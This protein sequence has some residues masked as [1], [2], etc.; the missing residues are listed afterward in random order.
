[1][2]VQLHSD[3]RELVLANK[4]NLKGKKNANKHFYS[5]CKLLPDEWSEQRRE[6]QQA[7]FKAHHANDNKDETQEKDRIEIK[8]RTLFI[9]KVPQK[10]LLQPPKIA[11]LFPERGE[12]E[13]IDRMKLYSSAMATA[14]SSSFNAHVIKT[15]ST[16][17]VRCGYVKVKQM[18]P[19]AAHIMAA[20]TIKNNIEGYQDDREF[21]AAVRI[22]ETINGT[23]TPNIAVYVVRDY[24]GTHI[25]PRRHVLI[26]TVVKE[27]IAKATQK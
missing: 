14:E 5:V 6:L 18:F 3:L 1:M 11:D 10:K 9:N 22:L 27:A 19:Q 12:Q 16:T 8:N 7:V 25:G 2:K 20:F 26:E 21:G 24:D 4:K 17:E 15:Q 13:K 23:G